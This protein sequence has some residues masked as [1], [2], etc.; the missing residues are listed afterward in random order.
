VRGSVGSGSVNGKQIGR[1]AR[2][3]G[4]AFAALTSA[5]AGQAPAA[6]LL[7]LRNLA[8]RPLSEAISSIVDAFC[9]PGILDED[10]IRAAMA[11]ALAEAFTN[12]DQ[13]DLE[14]ITDHTI[15]V[16][17]RCFVAELVFTAVIAEQGQ[18]AAVVTPLQAVKRENELRDVIR[19]IADVV[20]TP[21]LQQVA[22]VMT[23]RQIAM[24]VQRILVMVNEE[25]SKW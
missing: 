3:S 18:S 10:T 12:L 20:A 23:P 11:E 5:A 9:P 6:G 7:D 2:L 19:E 21:I 14:A 4:N 16:A 17:T 25:I 15:I 22:H 1:A 8:G 24:L 13:F